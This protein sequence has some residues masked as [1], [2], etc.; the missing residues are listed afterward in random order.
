MLFVEVRDE[1][2]GMNGHETGC[3]DKREGRCVPSIGRSARGV[4]GTMVDMRGRRRFWRGHLVDASIENGG[5]PNSI[6]CDI[7]VKNEH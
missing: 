3:K 4:R 7:R 2:Y 6:I 1:R 5:H